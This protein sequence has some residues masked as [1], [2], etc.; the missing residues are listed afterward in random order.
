MSTADKEDLRDE[1]LQ[2]RRALGADE[3]EAAR[4]LIRRHVVARADATDW[5]CIAAYVPLRTEPGSTELLDELE[6]RGV[7]VLVPVTRADRDLDWVRWGSTEP[8]GLAALAQADAVL[9][10]AL[11]VAHDGTRL[12]RGGGSYDRALGRVRAGAPIAA[13]LYPGE[14]LAEV[15]RDPWDIAVTAVVTPDGWQ[16]LPTP[17]G[18]G[19]P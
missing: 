3:I 19:N 16:D 4:S 7:R 8:L 1:Q 12:G 13:L 11:A 5:R 9:V 14:F 17:G 10:P 6:S 2:E 18:R 15:P